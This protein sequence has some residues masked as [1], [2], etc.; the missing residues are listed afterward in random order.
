MGGDGA[1]VCGCCL[2]AVDVCTGG[3]A[4]DGESRVVGRR[5]SQ[6]VCSVQCCAVYWASCCVGRRVVFGRRVVLGRRVVV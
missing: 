1:I 4:W 5:A 3:R 2:L 6:S